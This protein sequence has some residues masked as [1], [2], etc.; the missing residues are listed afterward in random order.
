MIKCRLINITHPLHLSKYISSPE[1]IV[2]ATK[3]YID[4]A[5]ESGGNFIG[6]FRLDP[7]I[8]PTKVYSDFIIMKLQTPSISPTPGL[9]SLEYDMMEDFLRDWEILGV[10]DIYEHSEDAKTNITLGINDK[11]GNIID[12]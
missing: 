6:V 9:L 8:S 11:D 10:Y 12:I 7:I 3:F 4:K 5:R 2:T 1:Y